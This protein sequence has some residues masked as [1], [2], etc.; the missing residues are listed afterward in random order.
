MK[1]FMQAKDFMGVLAGHTEGNEY[2]LMSESPNLYSQK[3]HEAKIG[4]SGSTFF[5]KKRGKDSLYESIKKEGVTTPVELKVLRTDKGWQEQ[6]N[7]GHHRVVA[8]H[9]I[10][11]EMIIPVTYK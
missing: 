9:D 2:K 11:P 1:M 3:L 10:D 6:I 7:D 8:S 4:S 5:E